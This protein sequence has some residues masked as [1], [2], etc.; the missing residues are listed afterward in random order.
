MKKEIK[1]Q[2]EL[3]KKYGVSDYTVENNKI[4]INGYLDLSSLTTAD[5]DFLKGTTINGSL[6]LSSLTTADKDFLKG[7][8]I[9]GSLYLSSLTTADIV[10]NNVKQLKA[11]YNKRKSNCYFDGILSKVLSVSERKGLAIYRTPF[12]FVVEKGKYYSHGV[13]AKKAIQDLQFKI[14][15]EKLKKEPIKADTKFTVK[16]YRNLTGACDQGCRGFMDANK[17]PYTIVGTG[18][19]E[20]T[21][22]KK[23]ILAKDLLVILEKSKPFGYEKFKSLLTF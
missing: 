16:Y 14:V 2:I 4:T 23:P 8:T 1:L 22:E 5:K 7:T 17:I 6:Y 11:G 3:L 12:G 15:S 19:D 21:V 10:K 13:A 9:N 20:K 18:N